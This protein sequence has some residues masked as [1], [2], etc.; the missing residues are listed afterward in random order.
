[1]ETQI[2]LGETHANQTEYQYEDNKNDDTQ[3]LIPQQNQ[4]NP[5]TSPEA[6][7][8]FDP[9][10]EP[11]INCECSC[12]GVIMLLVLIG[13]SLADIIIGSINFES[14]EII[15]RYIIYGGVFNLFLMCVL[16]T[17][18]GFGI[19]IL[20]LVIL[21]IEPIRVFG[22]YP[23][24]KLYCHQEYLDYAF[25]HFVA[26]YSLLGALI[27]FGIVTDI[28]TYFNKKTQQNQDVELKCLVVAKNA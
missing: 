2:E 17:P 9:A 20:K 16:N 4:D 26:D 7:P 11:D 15:S 19:F 27:L 25:W 10:K 18:S 8:Q 6:K 5:N 22:D 13:Y 28:I 3:P 14:C 12:W 24:D 23:K 1:M 21:I